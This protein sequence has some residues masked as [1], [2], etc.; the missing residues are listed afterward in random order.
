M[1]VDMST[2]QAL[3]AQL[4]RDGVRL[5][6][7]GDR[8]Y[9]RPEAKVSP[10]VREL[11]GLYKAEIIAIL[12]NQSSVR[13]LWPEYLDGLGPQS[14]DSLAPCAR[15][16]RGSWVRYGH[17]VLCI[18]CTQGHLRNTR[19]EVP[20]QVSGTS[21]PGAAS[22]DLR[23]RSARVSGQEVGNSDEASL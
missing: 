5:L 20:R 19:S 1:A 14:I 8:L 13:P 11:L 6:A 21:S 2:P 16:G 10:K 3:V 22:Q 15:C 4:R 7:R 17:T 23:R 9:Y 18:E 12:G